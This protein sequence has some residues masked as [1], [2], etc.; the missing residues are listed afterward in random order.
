MSTEG[1]VKRPIQHEAKPSGASRPHTKCFITQCTTVKPVRFC[2]IVVLCAANFLLLLSCKVTA[3]LLVNCVRA[4]PV[5]V[6]CRVFGLNPTL[7]AF[8]FVRTEFLTKVKVLSKFL[9]LRP[10]LLTNCPMFYIKPS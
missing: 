3:I 2:H 7:L 9:Q 8:F 6:S 1:G 4:A 5:R 10:S